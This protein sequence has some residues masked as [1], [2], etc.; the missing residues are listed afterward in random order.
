MKTVRDMKKSGSDMMVALDLNKITQSRDALAKALYS[1]LFAW[2]VKKINNKID[3][4]D[5]QDR[6]NTIGVLDIY[7]F[8]HFST[9]GYEQLLINYCSEKLQ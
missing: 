4:Q 2:L 6:V 8:E 7:G 3:A 5:G 9:N 1:R